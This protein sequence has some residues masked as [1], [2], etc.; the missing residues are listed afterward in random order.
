MVNIDIAIKHPL[1]AQKENPSGITQDETVAGQ[2]RV[3]F[4]VFS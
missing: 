3:H 2:I 4:E 1:E